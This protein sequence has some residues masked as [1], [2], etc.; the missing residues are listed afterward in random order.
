MPFGYPQDDTPK[1]W[2]GCLAAY[3]GGCL[4]GE[5]FAIEEHEDEDDLHDAVKKI[6][7]T[8]PEGEDAEEFHLCDWENLPGLDRYSSLTEVAAIAKSVHKYGYE[9][10]K[11]LLDHGIRYDELED[12]EFSVYESYED[13][14]QQMTDGKIVG[15]RASRYEAPAS[16]SLEDARIGGVYLESLIDMSDIGERMLQSASY[17]EADGRIVVFS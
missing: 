5:W 4:H 8:S 13:Y 9:I 3:N 14:A 6:L 17:A 1:V 2:I 11:A 15:G 7:S 10:T 16:I 12:A